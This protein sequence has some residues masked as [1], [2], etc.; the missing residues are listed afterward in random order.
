MKRG[1]YTA[2]PVAHAMAPVACGFHFFTAENPARVVF[3]AREHV[4]VVR[5]NAIVYEFKPE[6]SNNIDL[7]QT[8]ERNRAIKSRSAIRYLKR[9]KYG[10]WTSHLI[11][12]ELSQKEGRKVLER[13]REELEQ[14]DLQALYLDYTRK[15]YRTRR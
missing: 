6:N 8:H 15:V 12:P 3:T 5:G 11:K 10:A 2:L 14:E 7:A 13:T 1:I 9:I 4:I